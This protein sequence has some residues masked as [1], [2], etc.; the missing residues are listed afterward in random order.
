MSPDPLLEILERRASV[1]NGLPLVLFIHGAWQA[2]WCW[3]HYTGAF[4]EVGFDCFAVSLRGHGG[5]GNSKSL[6]WTRIRDYVEDVEQAVAGLDQ[7]PIIIGHSMGGLVTQKYLEKHAVPAAVLL[8]SVPTSGVLRTTLQVARNHPMAFLK[9]NLTMRLFPIVG[10]RE[11][12]ESILFCP[13]TDAAVVD[14]VWPRLQDE[15]YMAYLDM[16]FFA[17]PAPR[18]VQTPMLVIGGERDRL[19]T[20]QEMKKTAAAYGADLQMFPNSHQP[21]LEMNWRD[22]ASA[23]IEWI[24]TTLN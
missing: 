2:A 13:Q 19:F 3:E 1:P 16:M 12:A 8:A 11:M 10:S 17:L 20:E 14:A 24:T 21:M 5:S 18:K 6:R 9:T 22:S 23:I 4:N 15:S 7:A